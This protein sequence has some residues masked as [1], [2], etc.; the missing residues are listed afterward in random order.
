VLAAGNI[1]RPSSVRRRWTGVG[2]FAIGVPSSDRIYDASA[3]HQGRRVLTLA[4]D[5]RP[6]PRMAYTVSED[7]RAASVQLRRLRARH[8]HDRSHRSV[9]PVTNGLRA[10]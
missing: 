2:F 6:E 9:E 8:D 10:A 4:A 1:Q 7:Q 5:D 3:E